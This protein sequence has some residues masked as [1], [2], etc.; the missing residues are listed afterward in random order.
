LGAGGVGIERRWSIGLRAI[1]RYVGRTRR[2]CRPTTKR[3]ADLL[4]RVRSGFA[5]Y[6]AAEIDA[7]ELDDLIHQ[8]KRASIDL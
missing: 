8:Y 2:L 4:E 1:R 6:D 7:F 5:K 3:L